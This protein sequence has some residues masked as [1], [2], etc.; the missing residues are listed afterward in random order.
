MY[1]PIK[2]DRENQTIMGVD[3]S[4]V[5]DFKATLSSLGSQMFEGYEPTPHTLTLMRDYMTHKIDINQL[6]EAIKKY[7]E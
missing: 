5:D 7:Y 3:F 6:A 4:E 1:K 2:I